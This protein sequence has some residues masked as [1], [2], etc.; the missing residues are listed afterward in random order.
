LTHTSN[1]PGEELFS[2]ATDACGLTGATL[3]VRAVQS[4]TD[5]AATLVGADGRVLLDAPFVVAGF[6]VP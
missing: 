3:A 5:F 2:A 6:A 1:A 4:R